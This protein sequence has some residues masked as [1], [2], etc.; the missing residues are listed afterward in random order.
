MSDRSDRNAAPMR[1]DEQQEDQP[2]TD[3]PQSGQ[4]PGKKPSARQLRSTQSLERLRE[5]VEGAAQELKRLR[6]ENE[7]LVA[8]IAELEARPAQESDAASV[9][10]E[11]DPEALR[12]KVT[13][14]IEAIDQYLGKEA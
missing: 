3:T 4:K 9:S 5:K 6:E 10:F 2:R 12:R 1:G 8:R 11:E 13:G 14:F 7:D